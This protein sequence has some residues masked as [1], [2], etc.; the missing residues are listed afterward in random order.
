MRRIISV[1]TLVFAVL[2]WSVFLS[3]LATALLRGRDTPLE[4]YWS[5]SVMIHLLGVLVL[6]VFTVISFFL[7]RPRSW[8]L[9]SLT[10]A[11]LLTTLLVYPRAVQHYLATHPGDP[12]WHWTSG[13]WCDYQYVAVHPEGDPQYAGQVSLFPPYFDIPPKA[14]K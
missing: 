11:Y 9:P 5:L 3:S 13:S 7:I 2:V 10:A 12:D 8:V 4:S 6:P 14:S 1:G